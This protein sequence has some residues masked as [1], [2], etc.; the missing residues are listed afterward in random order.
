[1]ESKKKKKV[2]VA[3]LVSVKIDFKPTKVKRDKE[4][5][6]TLGWLAKKKKEVHYIMVKESM[7]RKELTIINIYVPNTGAPRYIK[8]VLKDLRRDLDS[9]AIIVGDFSTPLL[10]LDRMMR[11]KINKD[12]QDLNA[13]LDQADLI[14]IYRTLHPKSTEY[15]FLSAPYSKIDPIIESKSLLSKCKRTEIITNS[16]SDLSAIKLE[17]SI[18]KL[19]QNHT[20]TW[21][22]NNWLLNDNWINNEMKAEIKMF[23]KT[24]ENEYTMYQNLWGTFKALSIFSDKCPYEKQGKI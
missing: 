8:Q 19:T 6:Y 12:I 4:V 10:I 9:H 7:Q 13:D 21:K 17:L 1:M 3:I 2:G 16:L 11:Q 20:T 5:H 15:T 14:D 22:L 24:N 23:F 18:K